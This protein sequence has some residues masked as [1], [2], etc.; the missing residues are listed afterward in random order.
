MDDFQEMCNSPQVTQKK[1]KKSELSSK[2]GEW[3]NN[4][5]YFKKYS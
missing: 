3:F 5:K 4:E 1:N 2:N